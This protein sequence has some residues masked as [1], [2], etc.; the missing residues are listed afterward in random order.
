MYT[1]KKE[2]KIKLR[3]FLSDIRIILE[4]TPLSPLL[5]NERIQCF[6]KI[7]FI[8]DVSD[9]ILFS[10]NNCTDKKLNTK[11]FRN[12]EICSDNVK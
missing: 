10:S 8:Y 6:Y 12:L 5:T 3:H 11:T 7:D 4:N 2:E 1:T 9:F